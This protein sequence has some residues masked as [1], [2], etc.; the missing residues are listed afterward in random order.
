MRRRIKKKMIAIMLATAIAV[1]GFW[2][3][4]SLTDTTE[5]RVVNA[6][7]ASVKTVK[8]KREYT[9]KNLPI[10]RV[11]QNFFIDRK[12]NRIYGT[13]IRPNANGK[14]DTLLIQ[15]K[16]KDKTATAQ[17]F[18]VIKNGGHG[19]SL[20]GY[21]K[22]KALKLYVG[23]DNGKGVTLIDAAVLNQTGKNNKNINC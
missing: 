15:F 12:N 13:M 17:S 3:T 22:G 20:S 10:S 23:S 5:A 7:T 6:T 8:S 14:E 9:F 18:L 21:Y 16:I 1:S 11:I 4:E 19:I 2:V